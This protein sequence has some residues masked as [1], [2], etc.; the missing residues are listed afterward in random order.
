MNIFH[1]VQLA[2][3]IAIFTGISILVYVDSAYAVPPPA[4][5]N[6][7]EPKPTGGGYWKYSNCNWVEL[8]PL[9]QI[10]FG[11][12]V[13]DIQ[14]KD[15]LFLIH[16]RDTLKPACVTDNGVSSLVWNPDY[17]WAKIRITGDIGKPLT[18]ENMCFWY[19]DTELVQKNCNGIQ[20]K[21]E[22]TLTNGV[23]LKEPRWGLDKIE[24]TIMVEN[25]GTMTVKVPHAAFR[26]YSDIMT[27]SVLVDGYEV[28]YNSTAF[29]YYDEYEIEYPKNSKEIQ[30]VSFMPISGNDHE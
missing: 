29:Q 27:F 25:N 2:T 15:G 19:P 21:L 3:V 17:G 6:E 9:K 23:I 30:I 5:Q 13:Q 14:C 22:A 26:V 28:L 12:P 16:Q 8:L 1:K 10:K 24:Y 11:V 20:S 7:Q 18:Q 4:C